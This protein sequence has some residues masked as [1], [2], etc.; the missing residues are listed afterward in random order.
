[1]HLI[2]G[3]VRLSYFDPHCYFIHSTFVSCCEKSSNTLNRRFYTTNRT[4]LKLFLHQN[5]IC[6]LKQQQNTLSTFLRRSHQR[7]T[8]IVLLIHTWSKTQDATSRFIVAFVWISNN[9]NRFAISYQSLIVSNYKF[10]WQIGMELNL[11][12]RKRNNIRPVMNNKLYFQVPPTSTIGWMSAF[13][14]ITYETIYALPKWLLKI[15]VLQMI[16]VCIYTSKILQYE[17]DSTMLPI[18]FICQ[19]RND[20][21]SLGLFNTAP[22]ICISK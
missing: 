22:S 14:F 3:I 12:I 6:S 20:R 11:R 2:V 15:I 13:S 21:K 9:T 7:K 1:M 18:D 8:L 19:L 17:I 5:I 16:D 4:L 10:I